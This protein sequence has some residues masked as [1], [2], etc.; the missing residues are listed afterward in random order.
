M[1]SPFTLLGLAE[2]ATESEVRQQWRA[3]LHVHHPDVGGDND[4]FMQL[5]QAFNEALDLAHNR[6]CPRCGGSGFVE[7]AAGGT[8]IKI[9][10]GGC[11]G[12]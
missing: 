12:D 6:K 11:N 3:L 1:D 8:R 4:R 9:R 7:A 5:R 10:C 2:T